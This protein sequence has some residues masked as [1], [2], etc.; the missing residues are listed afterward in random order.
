M[1]LVSGSLSIVGYLSVTP[2]FRQL[3][4]DARTLPL[5]SDYMRTWYVGSVTMA[6]PMMGNGILISL[7]DSKAAS[8][9][10]V[11]GALLNCILDP[12][13][14]FGWFGFP[15]LGIL[16]AALA[17]VV[18]QLI[19]C[20]WLFWL[21]SRKYSLLR[22]KSPGMDLFS[23][24]CRR[25]LYFA[26]PGSLSMILTPIS[27][28]VIT[29]LISRHGYAAVAAVG[30]AGRV[31]LFAF[32]IPMALGISLVPFISQNFGARRLDR[33]REAKVYATRFAMLYGVG[34]AVVFFVSAPLL[35]RLF[36]ED[37]KVIGI[38]VQYFRIISF[39]YGLME[40]HRYCGFVFTG[41]HKPILATLNN[42]MRI[43]VL[44]IPLSLLGS[45]FF[46]IGG[47]FFARL[48]TDLSAGALGLLW[49]TY[50]LNHMKRTEAGS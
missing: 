41:I 40:V 15:V 39:G 12:V 14:I 11:L 18:S 3:G 47:I 8:R 5:I 33:I 27:S 46:G 49:V 42:A 50:R 43:L 10:M 32:V 38:F 19:S 13:M 30:A 29:A 1:A 17:T 23:E 31:E 45:L 28:G 21:L 7:G 22:L 6:I 36:S 2:V 25:I 4:A 37:P 35:G 20:I 48:A 26:I 16:G 44:L 34:I 9:F 24:S